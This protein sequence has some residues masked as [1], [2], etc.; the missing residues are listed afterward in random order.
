MKD[1]Q[2]GHPVKAGDDGGDEQ[3]R[4]PVG[5]QAGDYVDDWGDDERSS[6]PVGMQAGVDDEMQQLEDFEVYD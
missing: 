4:D 6:D 2:S 5:T 1:E 3:S